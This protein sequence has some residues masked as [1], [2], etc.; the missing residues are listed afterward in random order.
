MFFFL[1]LDLNYQII[2]N[3]K[4]NTAVCVE[5]LFWSMRSRMSRILLEIK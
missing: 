2:A 3:E 4:K 5:S 1:L